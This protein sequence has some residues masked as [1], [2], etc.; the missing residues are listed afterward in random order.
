MYL[1]ETMT[2]KPAGNLIDVRL[3]QKKPLMLQFLKMTHCVSSLAVNSHTQASDEC[4]SQWSE[5]THLDV[6][7]SG[8]FTEWTGLQLCCWELSHDRIMIVIQ[9]GLFFSEDE[10]LPVTFDGV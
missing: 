7:A 3:G 1:L 10:I 5:P 9:F 4:V 2:L 6:E 8:H